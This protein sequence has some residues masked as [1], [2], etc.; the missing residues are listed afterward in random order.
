MLSTK[1]ETRPDSFHNNWQ[2]KAMMGE[3]TPSGGLWKA[4]VDFFFHMY[5]WNICLSCPIQ[6]IILFGVLRR[7]K[8]L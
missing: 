8:F 6:K 4:N 2:A 1:G 7:A 5:V 3:K